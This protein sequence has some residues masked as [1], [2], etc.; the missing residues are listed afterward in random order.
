MLT[1]KEL[2]NLKISLVLIFLPILMDIKVLF[3][4]MKLL[5]N[6]FNDYNISNGTKNKFNYP[7]IN[8]LEYKLKGFKF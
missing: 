6:N 4:I 2:Q 5:S 3:Q 7:R 8:E 1:D